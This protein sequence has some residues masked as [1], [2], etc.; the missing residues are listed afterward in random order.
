MTGRHL[1]LLIAFATYMGRRV[2]GLHEDNPICGGN[3]ATQ[4]ARSYL[5]LTRK[6]ARSLVRYDV[7]MMSL[8]ISDSV[9]VIVHG[10]DGIVW[11]RPVDMA[12]E[13][14]ATTPEP[15]RQRRREPAN[16]GAQHGPQ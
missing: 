10:D 12:P 9:R 6:I 13:E 15:Q 5:L 7:S 3:F 11:I 8:Q 2:R 4:L 14:V 1:N 16:Q